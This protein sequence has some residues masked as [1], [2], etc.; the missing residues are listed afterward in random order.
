VTAF[1]WH[2][3]LHGVM[4]ESGDGALLRRHQLTRLDIRPET[5]PDVVGDWNELAKLFAA[6]SF[7]VVVWDPPHIT[8][9][10]HG[11]VGSADWAD[12]Y[13]TVATAFG[14]RTSATQALLHST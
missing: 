3:L 6:H 13:G 14:R 12:R 7:D 8:E 4:A 10:G 11:L 9:A 5:A 2:D 1:G